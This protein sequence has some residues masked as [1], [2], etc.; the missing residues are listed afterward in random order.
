MTLARFA[1]VP[2]VA[3]LVLI[4]QADALGRK[5][6][7]KR[8]PVPIKHDAKAP[9]TKEATKIPDGPDARPPGVQGE[10][11]IPVVEATA[12]V[13]AQAGSRS[14]TGC[15]TIASEAENQLW[16]Y[17][18]QANGYRETHHWGI[19][20]GE[21]PNAPEVL[22]LAVRSELL[23]RFDL[24]AE[25]DETTDLSEFETELAL[26]RDRA[27]A[28][29]D[30]AEA[31]LMRRRDPRTLGLEYWRGRALL[32]LGDI[33][34]GLAAFERAMRARSVEGWKLRGMLAL[35][36]LY[37]GNLD[38]ALELAHRTLVDAPRTDNVIAYYILALVLDRAGD[39]AGAAQRMQHARDR[40]GDGSQMR[41][42]E[43]ALP[44]HERL[45]LRAY[46]QTM[47]K[48]E[49]SALRLWAAYLAR[50]EPEDPERRLAERHQLSLR[51]LPRNLG[52]PATA[53]EGR[54][55]ANKP[56][57]SKAP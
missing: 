37:A 3:L 49:S 5:V 31:E 36:E 2:F 18:E 50:P 34:G 11:E 19:Q 23:R 15:S 22:T 42:L 20:A 57:D 56:G 41:T 48:D 28:W 17:S 44:I 46:A 39:T 10:R 32:S 55:A 12:T 35:A 9:V 1:W 26:S 14:W 7:A 40:D 13:W 6:V 43:T 29:I 52:G 54:A 47:R 27:L 24:P 53:A 25:L 16:T 51:P 8:K 33:D 45:Y 4:H 30:D 21:C 38:P